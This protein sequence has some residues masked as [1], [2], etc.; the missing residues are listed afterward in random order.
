[1]YVVAALEL[2]QFLCF[3]C[4][5]HSLH[6]LFTSLTESGVRL[7]GSASICAAG[8]Q[9]AHPWARLPAQPHPARDESGESYFLYQP[10]H[11]GQTQAQYNITTTPSVMDGEACGSI[12][13]SPEE[14]VL[15]CAIV[16]PLI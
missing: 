13:S 12:S 9:E 11:V 4:E 2:I 15:R 8:R 6:T 5:R 10:S 7:L 1:M 16:I 14:L 3:A